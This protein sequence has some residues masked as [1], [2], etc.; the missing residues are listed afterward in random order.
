MMAR[1]SLLISLWL[2]LSA[3]SHSYLLKA[4]KNSL[5]ID[6]VNV[7]A[8]AYHRPEY[9]PA[10]EDDFSYK[11]RE[12]SCQLPSDFLKDLKSKQSAI[13]ECLNSIGDIGLTYY[14]VPENQPFLEIDAND[15]A[16]PECALKQLSKIPLPREIYFMGRDTTMETKGEPLGCYSISFSVKT[17]QV[18]STESK[19]AKKKIKLP[20]YTGRDLLTTSDLYLWYMTSVFNILKA[21]EKA[22]GKWWAV[23]VPETTCRACFHGD[24][25]F[26]D[27]YSGKIKPVFWP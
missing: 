19:V 1:N 7:L 27:K 2:S 16:N 8:V 6:Q 12:L 23:P 3:C 5:V 24:A 11:N 13:F 26:N 20:V 17:N 22:L 10:D 18:M 4:K 21:D 9:A 25:L 14:Y 15:R